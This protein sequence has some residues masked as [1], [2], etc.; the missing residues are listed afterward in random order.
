MKTTHKKRIEYKR[1]K[2]HPLHRFMVD[3]GDD[4]GGDGLGW[5]IYA[6][7]NLSSVKIAMKDLP[8]HQAKFESS[9][10]LSDI[11]SSK[12]DRSYFGKEYI[13]HRYSY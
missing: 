13:E 7:S 9:N 8:N 5:V 11:R 1:K 6:R 12:F 3:F 2:Y 4:C 10:N